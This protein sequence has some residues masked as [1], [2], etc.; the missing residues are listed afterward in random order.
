MKSVSLRYQINS[1]IE[2]VGYSHTVYKFYFYEI[3]HWNMCNSLEICTNMYKRLTRE[4]WEK[5]IPLFTALVWRENRESRASFPADDKRW[6]RR[7]GGAGM[8]G[9]EQRE[10]WHN[11][12]DENDHGDDHNDDGVANMAAPRKAKPCRARS[13]GCAATPTPRTP[14]STATAWPTVAI[15]TLH[16]RY[17]A[18]QR[19]ERRGRRVGDE[20]CWIRKVLFR[21]SISEWYGRE[22]LSHVG[23][24]CALPLAA[25]AL[26]PRA[27]L[28]R[29]YPPK[30]CP[31]RASMSRFNFALLV[32]VTLPSPVVTKDPWSSVRFASGD[33]FSRVFNVSDCLI[34]FFTLL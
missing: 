30:R 4:G 17:D 7:K 22:R 27:D 5:N 13:R 26:H 31:P 1:E 2:F 3:F 10:G 8:G 29:A 15:N 21:A 14:S 33:M 32:V 12:E 23:A 24:T 28:S 18:A 34:Y 9:K 16:A 20:G 19:G 25:R 11:N 6:P